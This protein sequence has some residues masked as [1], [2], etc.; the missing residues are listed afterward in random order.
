ML[1][2]LSSQHFLEAGRKCAELQ[3]SAPFSTLGMVLTS[4]LNDH[5]YQAGRYVCDM[6]TVFNSSFLKL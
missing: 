1:T 4:G 3:G 5:W 2:L 6:A